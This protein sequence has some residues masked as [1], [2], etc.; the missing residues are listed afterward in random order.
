MKISKCASADSTLKTQKQIFGQQTILISLQVKFEKSEFSF[1]LCLVLHS[2]KY[3]NNLLRIGLEIKES[4]C[5]AVE[6]FDFL[7]IVIINA[8][9]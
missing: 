4:K 7:E 2:Q 8:L 1:N 6:P 3:F 9:H 5:G